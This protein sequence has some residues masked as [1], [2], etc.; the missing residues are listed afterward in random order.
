M[1]IPSDEELAGIG[2]E[3]R[4]RDTAQPCRVARQCEPLMAESVEMTNSWYRWTNVLDKHLRPHFSR[5]SSHGE[6]G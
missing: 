5:Q 1:K 6:R 3:R 4:R 2:G